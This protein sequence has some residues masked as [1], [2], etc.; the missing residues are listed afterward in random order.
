MV[1]TTTSYLQTRYRTPPGDGFDGVVR[2]SSGGYYATGA[3]LFDGWAVLTAAHLFPGG[4]SAGT[5]VHFE[6]AQGTQD[7][8]S[9]RVLLNPVYLEGT[10]NRDL[11]LVWLSQLAPVAADRYN[12][13][14]DT[15]ELGNVFTLAG[16]GRPAVGATGQ[17]DGYSGEFL[18]LKAQN[19]FDAEAGA[20]KAVMGSAMGWVPEAGS[21][22]GADFDDG[23]A[24]HDA[25]GLLMNLPQRGLA[26]DEGLITSGDSGGPALIHGLLAGVATS[27]ANLKT[28][29]L[30]PDVDTL[31]NSSFGEMA[32]WQ[33]V[34]A[35]QQWIDQ[36]LRAAYA[37]A[38]T[39]AH[40]VQKAV[41]EGQSGT[42]YVFFLVEFKG[43]RAQANQIVSVDYSTRDGTAAHGEDY[44]SVS[45]RLN[46]Y[47]GEDHAVIPVE[48][49]GDTK[50]EPE[51]T[52]YMDVTHPVGGDLDGHV[53]TLTAMRTI[54]NDDG[55]W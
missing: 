37:N 11:A 22:L 18:R 15:D 52:F 16:Y 36:S 45:G 44:L 39:T 2:V 30:N 25:L 6:T 53:V 10:G 31:S 8:A 51:E 46:L 48:I 35:N 4:S 26:A 7:A 43:V 20:L 54:L 3:L 29:Y 9:T 14:R 13:Y 23:L 1:S 40:E 28:A 17:S 32:F 50:V 5:V 12:L 55:L 21:Q 38:P 47:P 34:S 24:S 42:R 49:V 19:T 33:R 27:T 41:S